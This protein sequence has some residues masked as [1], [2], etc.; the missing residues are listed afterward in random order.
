MKVHIQDPPP[1]SHLC[2][3]VNPSSLYVTGA[4]PLPR[5]LANLSFFEA[6]K[7]RKII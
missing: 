5:P 7:E 1:K 3:L 4:P 6:R 2:R